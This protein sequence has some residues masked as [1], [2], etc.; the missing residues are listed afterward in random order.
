M[1]FRAMNLN[2]KGRVGI[3]CP[4]ENTFCP[5]I[6]YIL[7]TTSYSPVVLDSKPLSLKMS[8]R[9]YFSFPPWLLPASVEDFFN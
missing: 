2:C 3:M 9:F 5:L 1:V 7:H 6:T 4:I 8:V